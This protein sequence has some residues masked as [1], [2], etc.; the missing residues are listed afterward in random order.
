[1]MLAGC[2]HTSRHGAGDPLWDQPVPAHATVRVG[3][4]AG[5]GALLTDS[6]GRTLYMFPPDAG[7]HVTCTG[8]CAG[9]WPPLAIATGHTPTAGPGVTAADLGTLADPNTGQRIITYGGYPLYHYAGDLHAGTAN[10]QALFVNGGPW[11]AL[12]PDMQPI[13]TGS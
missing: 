11:Y 4:I 9:T 8:P 1:M 3:H 10:G 2:G 7:S 12:T 6:Q 5:L 13:T